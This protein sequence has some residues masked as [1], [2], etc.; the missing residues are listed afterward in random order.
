MTDRELLEAAA[1]A[2]ALEIH[3]WNGDMPV[4]YVE[5][6]SGDPNDPPQ[7]DHFY[8]NPLTDDGDALRLFCALPW[9]CIET[10]DLASTVRERGSPDEPSRVYLMWTEWLDEHNGDL[11]AATRRAIVRAAG[12]PSQSQGTAR[13]ARE[14][15]N[16]NAEELAR[17]AG[18]N[19][20]KHLSGR[21]SIA[22]ISIARFE[23]LIALVRNQALEDAADL[24]EPSDCWNNNRSEM[25]ELA[26]S[27]R[28]LK[29]TT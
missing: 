13:E 3:D 4:I 23:R 11:A 5:R 20:T 2:A 27:I 22:S 8:W 28:A 21:L 10:S 26:K 6:G 29:A 24:C 16:M 9:L 18:F 17:R 15:A 12:D 14:G 25:M 7:Q 19:V 1:R